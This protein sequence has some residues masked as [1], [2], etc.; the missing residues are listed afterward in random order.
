MKISKKGDFRKV[1]DPFRDFTLKT[2][3]G[4]R[5]S[6]H[7]GIPLGT[8]NHKIWGPPVLAISEIQLTLH[9]VHTV[10]SVKSAVFLEWQVGFENDIKMTPIFTINFSSKILI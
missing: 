10:H 9:K 3:P 1:L 2:V 8:K 5:D 6:P 7:F 4:F